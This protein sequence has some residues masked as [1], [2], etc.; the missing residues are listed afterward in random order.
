MLQSKRTVGGLSIQRGWQMAKHSQTIP[1]EPTP[2]PVERYGDRT[3]SP[4]R[5]GQATPS[6]LDWFIANFERLLLRYPDEWLAIRDGEVVAHAGSV[7]EL[8]AALR[9]AGITRPFIGRTHADAW[10]APR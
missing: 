1:N 3:P 5:A 9:S 6:D 10:L 2:V 8:K 4:P 7:R